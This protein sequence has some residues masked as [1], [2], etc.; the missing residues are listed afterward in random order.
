MQLLRAATLTTPDPERTASTY[1]EWL[2]YRTIER[3][4]IPEELA[5]SW[6]TPASTGKPYLLMQ[7]ESGAAV[8]L[9]LVAGAARPEYRPLRTFGWAAIE[10]CVRDV[11]HVNERLERSPFEIIGAP[12]ELDG[13]P[14][15]FPMQVA[16]PD[17]E[18]LF[19]TQIR[20][21]LPDYDLP[22]AQSLVDRPF[23]VVL[24]CSDLRESL[25]WFERALGLK[26]GR[27]MEIVFT[28]LSKA[29]GMPPDH[30]HR[31]ATVAHERD[32]FLELDQYPKAATARAGAPGELKPGVALATFLH[33]ALDEIR[34]A[35]I[36][37]PQ[38]R[39]GALYCGRR[40]GTLAAPDGTLVELLEA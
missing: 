12:R 26:I 40:A 6:G 16:G 15:I 20:A 8:Y 29:F 7:A 34:A 10:L 27:E 13:L 18:I 14:T 28:V 4:K 30:K 32:C 38:P 5:L 1:E 23:I 39:G 35:W 22:R 3:G 11:L 19:L 21:D 37:P 17:R 25:R 31:L 9:R 33:P 24:A 36:T 2:H